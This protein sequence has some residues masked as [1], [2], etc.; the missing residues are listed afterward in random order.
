MWW[1][2]GKNR[3]RVAVRVIGALAI[4]A[5]AVLLGMSTAT[6][7][8]SEP[9]EGFGFLTVEVFSTSEGGEAFDFDLSSDQP[10]CS[11][12][13]FSVDGGAFDNLAGFAETDDTGEL[14]QYTLAAVD[15][16]PNFVQPPPQTFVFDVPGVVIVAFSIVDPAARGSVAVAVGVPVLVDPDVI[17]DSWDFA[18][19]SSQAGCTNKIA[20]VSAAA[21][22]TLPIT[23]VV[24]LGGEDSEITDVVKA[25]SD[26][27]FCVYEIALTGLPDGWVQPDPVAFSF[28]PSALDH[29]QGG[30]MT[31]Y[32]VGTLGVVDV[33]K[34][35]QGNPDDLPATWQFELT[36]SQPGCS[37]DALTIDA[38]T[39]QV[40]GTFVD[41]EPSDDDGAAC[42]YV[43]SEPIVPEGWLQQEPQRVAYDFPLSG[44]VS[45]AN[46][47][48]A[49]TE[50]TIELFV[51]SFGD[52]AFAPE[53]WEYEITSTC[54]DEPLVV[55]LLAETTFGNN[56]SSDGPQWLF[57]DVPVVDADLN[58]CTYDVERA[59]TLNFDVAES[60]QAPLGPVS[61]RPED[62][63]FESPRLFVQIN[64]AMRSN[65]TPIY[66]S[67]PVDPP[68]TAVPTVV[69][70]AVVAP[71]A[72]AVAPPAAPVVIAAAAAPVVSPPA[73]IVA[74]APAP[75]VVTGETYGFSNS[76]PTI[77]GAASS[78]HAQLALT[79]SESGSLTGTALMLLF[80]GVFFLAV[81]KAPT[82]RRLTN[83]AD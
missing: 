63:T 77:H 12:W 67:Q 21:T 49:S 5:A 81:S 3:L 15:L 39:G 28:G 8:E 14:C 74:P 27:T 79:G 31:T 7:Q 36:S 62:A 2:T 54:L 26:G 51:N 45:F 32:P 56:P 4:G 68:A 29:L 83:G 17:P 47:D 58:G 70:P 53:Y 37:N 78:K 24:A 82:R 1:N 64:N 40:V 71:T 30:L 76:L 73:V 60:P 34:T 55:E 13:T 61:F 69:A 52:P 35:V 42:T 57:I 72:I 41:V 10:G 20:S 25:L 80:G 23:R 46:V 38:T 33:I 6:A 59:P 48:L 19:S 43:V 22:I 9:S 50:G 16:P 44:Y 65:P 11:N 75:V 18:I 66:A